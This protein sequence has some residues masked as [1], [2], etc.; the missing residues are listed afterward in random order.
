MDEDLIPIATSLTLLA[1]PPGA[2]SISYDIYTRKLEDD[3]PGGWG[4]ARCEFF[5]LASLY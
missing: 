4:S 2:Y 3:P 5:G 1:L